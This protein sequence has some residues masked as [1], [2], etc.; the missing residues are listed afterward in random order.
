[1]YCKNNLG[2]ASIS[3]M[4]DVIMGLSCQKI[5]MHKLKYSRSYFVFFSFHAYAILPIIANA[6]LIS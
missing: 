5:F 3:Q 1:M 2:F 4:N 6:L